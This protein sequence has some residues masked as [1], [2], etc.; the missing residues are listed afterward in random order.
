MTIKYTSEDNVISGLP[1]GGIGCGTLQV[2]P[3]GTRGVFTGLNN[4]EKPLGQL[5]WFRKG[6]GGD[7]RAS[8]PFAIFVEQGGKK[9]SKFLQTAHLDKCQTVEK[10]EFEAEFPIAKLK[11]KD[12][13]IPLDV[14]LLS[15]TPFI[16]NDDKNSSLPCVTYLFKIK[17][18]TSE[19]AEVSLLASAVNAVGE[20]NVGRFNK[21]WKSRGLT[22]VSFYKENAHPHDGSSKGDISLSTVASRGVTYLGEWQYVGESFRGEAEDRRFDAWRYFAEDGTLPNLSSGRI[23]Q[24]EGDEWMAALAVKFTLAPDEEKEIPFYYTWFMPNHHLGHM[25]ENWFSDSREIAHYIH[26]KKDAFLAKT[27]KWQRLIKE[28]TVDPWLKDGLINYLSIIPSASWWTKK[29][30]FVM[31]ENPVKWPLMDSLDVRYY[32]TMALAIFFPSLEKNTMMLFKKAQSG[33]GR[34]PHDL[35]RSQINCPS[36]GTTAGHPWKD[37]STK[38]ALMAYRDFLWTGDSKFLKNIYKSVK[39]AMEWEFTQDKDGNGLPDNEGKDQ[40]YDLWDFYGTNSY[41]SGIFLAALLASMKMAKIMGDKAFYKSCKAYFDK[42]KESFE[43]ELWTG[44]YYIAGKSKHI[45]YNACTAGQLNGQWYAHLLNLGYIHP[46]EHV[47]KAV[48]TM[49]ELNGSKSAFGAVNSIYPVRSKASNGVNPDPEGRDFSRSSSGPRRT[50]EGESII[51]GGKIDTSSYHSANVWVG[52]T[53][54]L[55]SLAIYEG[56][57][58]EGLDLAKKTWDNFVHNKKNVWY[59]PDVVFAKDGSLGDGELYVRNMSLWSVPF[60]LARHDKSVE[61]F[62]LKLEPKLGASF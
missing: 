45:T 33:D 19:K 26:K 22:G 54:A 8:N 56:F 29:N 60:A 28:S 14:S 37:L 49:L 39:K 58:K 11:F 12:K 7:Y 9:I 32:G 3:D 47:K 48:K 57:V 17:N 24:G 44:S 13:N 61:D 6:S 31:Y 21:V 40:T 27:Y 18:T 55:A 50:S 53:Y 5:H 46:E 38:Y 10:I 4:W 43:R 2:F 30:E 52:E 23:T 51:R 20:W 62:L 16:K 42:G 35:G 15:H 59:Q 34:I 36:G 1:L 41:S 25:Y